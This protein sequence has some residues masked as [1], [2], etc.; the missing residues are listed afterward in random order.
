MACFAILEA[1]AEGAGSVST[2][3]GMHGTAQNNSNEKLSHIAQEYEE[4]SFRVACR[5]QHMVEV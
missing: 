3:P 1:I 2:T 4:R 5:G